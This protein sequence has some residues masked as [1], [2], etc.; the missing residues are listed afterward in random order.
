VPAPPPPPTIK[1]STDSTSEW[2]VPR[3][4][5]EPSQI[6]IVLVFVSKMTCPVNGDAG[7]VEDV[8]IVTPLNDA[9]S[10]ACVIDPSAG[11]SEMSFPNFAAVT[12]PAA[13]FAVVTA[14]EASFAAVIDSSAGVSEMSFPNFAAVTAP[15]AIFAVVTALSAILSDVTDPVPI[16]ASPCTRFHDVP[17][18]CHVFVP[19]V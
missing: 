4:H 12:A 5:A 17:S 10:F 9:A 13:I 19:T 16:S 1:T 2:V 18:N 6:F 3:D 11:V 14:P 8:Q 15:A 7:F